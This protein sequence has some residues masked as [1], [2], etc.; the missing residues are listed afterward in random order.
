[1][2]KFLQKRTLSNICSYKLNETYD[3]LYELQQ[4]L[5]ISDEYLLN[6]SRNLNKN[7]DDT[8][9][10]T[11]HDICLQ[12]LLDTSKVA[13]DNLTT[14][15]YK[16]NLVELNVTISLLS[17]KIKFMEYKFGLCEGLDLHQACS[18]S[19][20]D[21][22]NILSE[23]TV[24]TASPGESKTMHEVSKEVE[25]PI[26]L[27]QYRNQIC[28]VPSESPCIA[29]LVPLVVKSLEFMRDSFWAQ[30]LHQESFDANR[31]VRLVKIISRFTHITSKN[32]HKELRK[33][34]VL[35]KNRLKS[36]KKH[37][38]TC[39]K[40]CLIL[41]KQLLKNPDP[42]I[43]LIIDFIS[44]YLPKSEE[45][46]CGLLL[47]Q[48]ILAHCFERFVFKLINRARDSS[49]NNIMVW[50]R[51]VILLASWKTSRD[52]RLRL[53]NLE[54]NPSTKLKRSTKIP[55]L[56]C[57]HI[58]YQLMEIDHRYIQNMLPSLRFKLSKVIGKDRALLLIDLTKISK[59]KFCL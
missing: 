20:I 14:W 38:V 5:G 2:A 13:R 53:T 58:A 34:I 12:E 15:Y 59:S 4:R 6:T 47:E 48:V 25:V 3:T 18:L 22:C 41:K 39:E 32:Q 42:V 21:F 33:D 17:A 36:S 43:E 26:W 50:L 45:R 54:M 44:Q 35:S 56:K 16:S 31:C 28:H 24:H 7:L 30:V 10:N 40:A 1:M 19:L 55:P 51:R 11:T 9:D 27:S 52:L 23:K 29:I 8:D 46:N 57:C 37:L 49:D